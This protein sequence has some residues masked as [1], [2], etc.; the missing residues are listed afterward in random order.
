MDHGR[1]QP[2][3]PHYG[4]A[5][6]TTTRFLNGLHGS[7]AESP[8]VLSYSDDGGRT[9]SA[10]EGDLGQPS[11]LHVPETGGG[12]ECDEDQFSIPEVASD[13]TL[14]VHFANEQNE[15]A[16]EANDSSTIR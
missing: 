15:A 16:W 6:L 5:Y 11:E 1:Q 2:G 3:S 7:Y 8:I 12:T 9:W 10:P 14:Y 13:G 4:R